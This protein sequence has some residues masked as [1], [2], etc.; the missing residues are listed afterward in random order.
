MRDRSSPPVILVAD[1]DLLVLEFVEK[2]L[3]N[4]GYRVCSATSGEMAVEMAAVM[5]ID[6]ALLDYRMPN[7]NGV[8]AGA[9]IYRMT[10][11]RFVLMSVHTDRDVWIQAATDGALGF[12][13]K[14]LVPHELD[15]QIMIALQRGAEFDRMHA[16][17]NDLKASHDENISKAMAGARSVNTAL[18]ILMEIRCIDRESG[19]HLL[20]EQARGSRRRLVEV[21]EELIANRERLYRSR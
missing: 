8:E 14:P 6:L 10:G 11:R 15:A 20:V 17:M 3:G 4:S 12:L 19:F 5:N 16:S 2:A 9:S 1:D 18:G 7:L 13:T 21:C